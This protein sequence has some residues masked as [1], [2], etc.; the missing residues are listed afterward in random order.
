MERLISF[1]SQ[2]LSQNFFFEIFEEILANLFK[3]LT[4][5]S[6]ENLLC[7]KRDTFKEDIYIHEAAHGIH[8]VGGAGLGSLQLLDK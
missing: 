3:P 5:S 1:G 2:I 4:I 7:T 8:L 6:E